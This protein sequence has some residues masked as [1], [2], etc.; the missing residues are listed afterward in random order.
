MEKLLNECARRDL[1][2]MF[3]VTA[4]KHIEIL[5]GLKIITIEG[6]RMPLFIPMEICKN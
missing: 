5:V 3:N 4:P 6:I 2:I 1:Q